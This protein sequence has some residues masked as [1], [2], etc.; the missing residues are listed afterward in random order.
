MQRKPIEEVWDQP[1]VA[2]KNWMYYAQQKVDR[3]SKSLSV[4]LYD[5]LPPEP[6]IIITASIQEPA[7]P[8]SKPDP[9]EL[10]EQKRKKDQ[11]KGKLQKELNKQEKQNEN[12]LKL[13]LNGTK[14]NNLRAN[15][16]A[17]FVEENFKRKLSEVSKYIPSIFHALG[18]LLVEMLSMSP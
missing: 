12:C 6:E 8:P 4:T 2:F 7:K 17:S 3:D 1:E 10:K 5:T 14:G 9:K 11:E 18:P 15:G 16:I 13:N